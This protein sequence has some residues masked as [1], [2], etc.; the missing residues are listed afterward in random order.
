LA[1]DPR[2]SRRAF[3]WTGSVVAF[4]AALAPRGFQRAYAQDATPPA[5]T[6]SIGWSDSLDDD[7]G[8]LNVVTTVAP[9][10]SIVRNV[11]GTRVNL[12]GIIP[13]GTDSHT[14]EPAPSDAK[15]LSKAD[16][17]LVNGLH[18][19]DPT[20][21]LANS[22]LKD[23]AEIYSLGDKTITEDQY[24]YDFS[25][26]KDEGKPN[27]HLWMN[28]PFAAKYAEL[29]M[30]KLKE[31]DS[32]NADYYQANYD[33]YNAVLQQL[34]QGIMTSVQTIPEQNRK[35]LTYHD[36]FAYFAQRYGMTVIGAVQP[37]DFSEPSPQE[38]AALID[39]IKAEKVPAV[40]GSEVYPST[41][42]EQI[43]KESGATYIDKLRDDEP[44]GDPGAPDH[45]YLG[46]ML[47]D[48]SLMI[49][50][51]G[52]NVD[53]LAGIQPYNTYQS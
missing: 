21:D 36:S 12:H 53:A 48:M 20:I 43:A 22:N 33:R 27:P 32:N 24:A 15:I 46:L 28:I 18:L 50:A 51:L 10:S 17:I 25:F 49:P 2:L 3:L 52:G 9:I 14:F 16:L 11:G 23:G 19:E 1:N 4:A 26:P 41:V 35:L 38:V 6:N 39:Q 34:D 42:L 5:P 47:N 44:P 7:N 45:T 13:D 37:S 30:G 29:A 8:K 40:F 31:R